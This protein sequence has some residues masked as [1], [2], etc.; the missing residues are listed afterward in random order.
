MANVENDDDL[1]IGDPDS[2]RD[3]NAPEGANDRWTSS[4]QDLGALKNSELMA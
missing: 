3:E 2:V 4:H 1:I